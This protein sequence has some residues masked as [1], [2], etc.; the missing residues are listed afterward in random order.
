MSDD[1][2][3]T[4]AVLAGRLG[5]SRRQVWRL[6]AAAKISYINVGVGSRPAYR[7]DVDTVKEELEHGKR[8]E[9]RPTMVCR[10]MGTSDE[11]EAL[12]VVAGRCDG[13]TGRAAVNAD[14]TR[15]GRSKV[16]RVA[17]EIFDREFG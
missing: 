2:A 10:D 17:D 12:G 3:V 9:K 4:A 1:N 15:R 16:Q 5:I 7:Y 14:S 8:G 13:K 11:E 6:T